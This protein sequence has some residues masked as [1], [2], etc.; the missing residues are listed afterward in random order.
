MEHSS[1]L[2]EAVQMMNRAGRAWFDGFGVHVEK[3]AARLEAPGYGP[4]AAA[5]DLAKAWVLW[6]QAL[7]GTSSATAGAVSILSEET[8]ESIVT[9]FDPEPELTEECSLSIQSTPTWTNFFKP[10]PPDTSVKLVPNFFPPIGAGLP[11]TRVGP[12]GTFSVVATPTSPDPHWNLTIRF[13]PVDDNSI[14]QPFDRSFD[15]I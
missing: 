4:D 12:G 7:A 10:E 11:E 14:L 8:T 3:A 2:A 13:E 5:G 15:I 6:L 1:P 9:T